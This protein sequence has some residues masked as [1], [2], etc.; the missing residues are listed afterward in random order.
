ME[1]VISPYILYLC[2][3]VGGIGVALAMPRGKPT[4]QA[5][6]ALIAATAFGGA[7]LALSL[8][9]GLE[10]MPNLFYYIFGFL[11]LASSL[12]VITHPKP[13]Y[14]ALFFIFT[15]LSSAGLYLLLSAEFMTFAL[16]IIYAGAILITYLFV[17]MLASQAPIDS[18]VDSIADYDSAAREPYSAV[19]V[20]FALLAALTG[21]LATGVS[22]LP[23]VD[24]AAPA[25]NP[26]LILVEL[27]RKVQKA[28]NAVGVGEE[29]L[30][31]MAGS[32]SAP[33]RAQTDEADPMEV[34]SVYDP[35]RRRAVLKVVDLDQFE[36]RLRATQ[37][38]IAGEPAPNDAEP[39]DPE[40]IDMLLRVDP[41]GT[42][43]SE[44]FYNLQRGA[45]VAAGGL[46]QIP[47]AFPED[48]QGENIE[49]VGFALLN[50]HPGAVELA[51]V[52]LLLA[53]VGAVIL[54]R[55]QMDV[56]AQ[57]RHT[58][59]DSAAYLGGAS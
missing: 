58:L 48:L 42:F 43:I 13:V 30:P 20:G 41:T 49:L 52:I 10:G 57:Q 28:F 39:F 36:A 15:I 21:M 45:V 8:K 51:G 25:K 7:V 4:P 40:V 34:H 6:G 18:D 3:I 27:P 33:R 2:L 54:A 59:G 56:V 47:I 26:D 53:M 17:I 14:A 38:K 23:A 29:A 46:A 9:A 44:D 24:P 11:A 22:N 31:M 19:F 35:E 1:S 50:E 16:I 37:A 32:L 12:R 5:I 55:K